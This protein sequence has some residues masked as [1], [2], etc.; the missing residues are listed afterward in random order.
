MDSIFVDSILTMNESVKNG[1]RED[2]EN[3]EFGTP[4]RIFDHPSDSPD[5]DCSVFKTRV[6]NR[7]AKGKANFHID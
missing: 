6:C 7:N 4:F 3:D 2:N 1:K 5:G